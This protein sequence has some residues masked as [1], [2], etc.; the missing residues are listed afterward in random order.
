[1]RMGRFFKATG[2]AIVLV[3]MLGS[4][5]V[6]AIITAGIWAIMSLYADRYEDSIIEFTNGWADGIWGGWNA[7]VDQ[8]VAMVTWPVRMVT[9]AWK[10]VKSWLLL[11]R[12]RTILGTT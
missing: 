8:I 10:G 9:R 6:W 4:E 1:M 7:A 3:S 5:F 11:R 2:L 12:T